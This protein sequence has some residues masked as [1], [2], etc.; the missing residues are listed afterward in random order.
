M[1]LYACPANT[2]ELSLGNYLSSDVARQGL[3]V[4]GKALVLLETKAETVPAVF[5][6]PTQ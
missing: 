5:A 3:R 4:V 1:V 2:E 6:P